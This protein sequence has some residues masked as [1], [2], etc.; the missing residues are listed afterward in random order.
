MS[1]ITRPRLSQMNTA[2]IAF[3]DPI[4][5]I[6]AGATSADVDIGFLMNRANGLLANVAIYWNESGN[7]FVTAFT[8]NSG[9]TDSNIV[10]SSYAALTTGNIT[11]T[12]DVIVTGNLTV[13]GTT[14]SVNSETVGGVEV[15][16]GNLVANSGTVSTSTTTGALVVKGGAGIGGDIHISGNIIPAT[17]NTYVLGDSDHRF[18]NLWLGPGTIYLTDAVD[19]TRTVDL[20]A[21][22]GVLLINGAEALQANLTSGNSSIKLLPNS[23]ITLTSSNVNT[24]VISK[25]GI[26][27]NGNVDVSSNVSAQF[28]IGDGTYITGLAPS[29]Q[30]YLFANVA[31]DVSPYYQAKAA[32][33]FTIGTV[34]T[35]S[36]SVST[37]PVLLAEFLTEVSHP[38]TSYI[39]VG[40]V[41][42]KYETRKATGNKEYITY[43]ELWK[44]TEGGTET[45]LGTSDLTTAVTTN[46]TVQQSTNLLLTTKVSLTTTDRLAV[47]LYAYLLSSPA[48]SISLLF[49]DNTI[50]GFSLPASPAS[51]TNFVPYVGATKDLNLGTRTLTV[52]NIE[53]AANVTYD[54]GSSTRWFRDLWLSSGTIHIGGATISQDPG[55]GAVAIVPTPTADN[56]NPVATVFTP[57]GAVT[58]ANTVGGALSAA[59]VA[60][61]TVANDFSIAG[62][63]TANTATIISDVVIGGNLTISGNISVNNAMVDRGIAGTNWDTITQMGTYVINRVSWSGTTGT[64]LDSLIYTGLLEV[65]NSSN[66][67]IT[68]N[69]RPYDSGSVASVYWTRSK[70]N[71]TWSAWR[72]IVNNSSQ[73]DGGSY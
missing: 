43:A 2:V 11:S 30:T 18:A 73:M 60:A 10:V 14:T 68:Q 28:F 52:G 55:T 21:S 34:S 12:G 1:G 45:K 46:Q 44:R 36:K 56:P 51:A 42:F 63:L 15:V 13:I 5:V 37:T 19:P 71:T 23:A 33:D 20:A 38:N 6:N 66:T 54:L 67:A 31:S 69:Y 17:T 70:F 8:S 41:N 32:D 72:E 16:A 59:D 25:T 40:I 62:N 9:A 22:G 27:V 35:V 39:P 48:A 4:T 29:I 64:P 3:R 24:A 65:T 49:D 47:K 58:A 61:A 7:T 50:S 26:T 57:G 53:P